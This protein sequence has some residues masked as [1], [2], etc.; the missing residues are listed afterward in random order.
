[1]LFFGTQNL[2]Q[3]RDRAIGMLAVG[4][5]AFIPGFYACWVLLGTYMGWHGYSYDILPSYDD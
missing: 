1:M 2:S 3:D 4:S 5:L